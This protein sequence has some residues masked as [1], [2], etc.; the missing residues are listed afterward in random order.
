[1]RE[2]VLL[3][4]QPMQWTRNSIVFLAVIFAHRLGNL[5]DVLL[6][7]LAVLLFCLASSVVHLVNDLSDRETGRWHPVKRPRPR[8]LRR[9]HARRPIIVAA[10]IWVAALTVASVVLLPVAFALIAFVALNL[11]CSFYFKHNVL[12]TLCGVAGSPLL[13]VAAGAWIIGVALSPWLY[14]C[15]FLGSLFM[16]TKWS[17]R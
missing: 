15:T 13:R 5:R 6:S 12:G 10:M 4:M 7:L 2:T 9:F 16:W 3:A 11:A 17:I 1:M 8:A 14:L